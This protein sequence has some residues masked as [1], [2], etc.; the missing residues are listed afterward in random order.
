MPAPGSTCAPRARAARRD[1]ALRSATVLIAFVGTLTGL[2]PLLVPLLLDR[3][4]FSS[5]EIGAVF[6]AGSVIWILASALAVR[7]GARAV[8]VGVAGPG[9]CCSAPP[10]SC[11]CSRSPRRA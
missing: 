3:E 6:A 2:V 4:G 5:G 10:R 11:P 7:A 1:P 9:S 8:T